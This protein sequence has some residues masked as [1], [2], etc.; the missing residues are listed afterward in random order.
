MANE[1]G[2]SNQLMQQ[3]DGLEIVEEGEDSLGG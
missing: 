3:R 1:R 2:G